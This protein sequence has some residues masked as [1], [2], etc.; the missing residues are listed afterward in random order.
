MRLRQ[1]VKKNSHAQLQQ[2]V[3]DVS[4]HSTGSREGGREGGLGGGGWAGGASERGT[5]ALMEGEEGE[6]EGGKGRR[7]GD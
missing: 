3:L 1:A 5:F 7:E 4:M 2:L 6:E